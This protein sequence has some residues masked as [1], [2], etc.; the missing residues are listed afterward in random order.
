MRAA[1]LG[2]DFFATRC[3]IGHIQ[4]PYG[5]FPLDRGLD[6]LHYTPSILEIHAG[7]A[8]IQRVMLHG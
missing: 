4:E 7:L 6:F 5:Q 1:A 3:D 2:I 8:T